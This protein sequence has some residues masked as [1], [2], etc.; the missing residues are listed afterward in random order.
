M[1]DVSIFFIWDLPVQ[2]SQPISDPGPLALP[3][4]FECGFGACLSDI[5]FSSSGDEPDL[6]NHCRGARNKH[7]N[8]SRD[9]L[10]HRRNVRQMIGLGAGLPR[11]SLN[12]FN[13]LG[14]FR[15]SNG[16]PGSEAQEVFTKNIS[17]DERSPS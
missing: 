12:V 11:L 6:G 4:T 17:A 9:E 8:S 3:E 10:G 5:P 14:P 1:G 7:R 13:H 15:H 16:Q 2:V